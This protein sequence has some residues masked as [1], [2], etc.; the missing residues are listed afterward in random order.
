MREKSQVTPVTSTQWRRRFREFLT[1]RVK[2]LLEF[3]AKPLAK[4]PTLGPTE[5]LL[6]KFGRPN[7]VANHHTLRD[8]ALDSSGVNITGLVEEGL[9]QFPHTLKGFQEQTRYLFDMYRESA[10]EIVRQDTILQSRLT[11]FDKIQSRVMGLAD[12]Q[13]NEDYEPMARASEAYLKRLFNENNLEPVYKALIEA[14]RK[15]LMLRDIVHMRRLADAIESQ[16]LCNICF[17]ESIQFAITP[18]GHTY[19]GTCVKKQFNTCYVC[20]G[21]VKERVRLFLG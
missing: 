17:E 4:H 21:P 9:K 7:F 20:R 19:C 13:I 6:R 8:V 3:A 16:P 10:D 12:L 1:G 14:Y 15:F 18:C 11:T 2:D 5:I